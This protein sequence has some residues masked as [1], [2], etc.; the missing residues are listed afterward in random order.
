M[1]ILHG[2]TTTA[3]STTRIFKDAI[4]IP[5]ALQQ[6]VWLV[7]GPLGVLAVQ[8]VD[9]ERVRGPVPTWNILQEPAQAAWSLKLAK[10]GNARW[11]VRLAPGLLGAVAAHPVDLDLENGPVPTPHR[12]ME[13]LAA[14]RQFKLRLATT[15]HAQV[16]VQVQVQVTA[17]TS[18]QALALVQVQETRIVSSRV[19][20]TYSFTVLTS[21]S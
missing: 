12:S 18:A 14:H 7:T 6:I 11:T 3:P 13:G 21:R 2:T 1:W 4:T 5:R 16:Q 20:S 8:P 10:T 19:E 15:A 17:L 9:P